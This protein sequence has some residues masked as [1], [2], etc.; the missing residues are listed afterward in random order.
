[1]NFARPAVE[2]YS[3]GIDRDRQ[4]APNFRVWEFASPCGADRVLICSN[5]VKLLQEIR[6]HF[7]VP[8]TITSGFRMEEHNR[9]VGGAVNSQH[10]RGTAADIVVRDVPPMQVAQF[11]EHLGAGAIGL[12]AG[13]VHVD[14]RAG[15]VRWDQRSGQAVIVP[16][17]PGFVATENRTEENITMRQYQEL[18]EM[19]ERLEQAVAAISDL[20]LPRFQSVEDVPAWARDAVQD[21]IDREILRGVDTNDLGLSLKEVRSKVF[22]QRR[23]SRTRE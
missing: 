14:T 23:E 10:L 16:G 13:S 1:M 3:L 15:R 12:Y 2:T 17:F 22:D 11:A 6:D 4:L 18:K 20:V 9:R 7:G 5:L 21:A 8:V 19:I